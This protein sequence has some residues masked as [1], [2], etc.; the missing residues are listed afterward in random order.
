MAQLDYANRGLW[1]Y[2]A[3]S[4]TY[5]I[6][7]FGI[8]GFRCHVVPSVPPEHW[9]WVRPEL[10]KA[11]AA[12]GRALLMLSLTEDDGHPSEFDASNDYRLPPVLWDIAKGTSPGNGHR[13]SAQG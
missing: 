9:K 4:C 1:R 7:E 13:R 2:M 10:E 3:D 12:R 8:D 6:S 11:A 5:W